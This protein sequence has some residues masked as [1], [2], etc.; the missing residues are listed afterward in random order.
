V[1]SVALAAAACGSAPTSAVSGNT[2]A[3]PDTAHS[4]GSGSPASATAIRSTTNA[5]LGTILVDPPG[6]TL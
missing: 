6:A 3:N 4:A 5:T 2:Y 1:L